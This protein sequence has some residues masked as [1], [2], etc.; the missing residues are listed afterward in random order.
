MPF[1]SLKTMFH[2][3]VLAAGASAPNRRDR[4]ENLCVRCTGMVPAGAAAESLVTPD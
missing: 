3:S 4:P 1:S 2:G